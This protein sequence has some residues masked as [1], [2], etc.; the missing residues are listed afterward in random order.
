MKKTIDGLDLEIFEDVY[1]P[2]ED[3]FLLAEN[4]CI[5]SD[6]KILEVGSGSGYVSIYLS[7]KYP[8]AEIFSLDINFSATKCTLQNISRN[9]VELHVINSDL[10]SSFENLIPFFDIILFNSPYLPVS[11]DNTLA[12]AWSGGIDGLTVIR[13]FLFNLSDYL[14]PTGSCYLVVSSYT[15]LIGLISII[16]EINFNYEI[17]D[18]VSEGG[19]KIL[20]YLLKRK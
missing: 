10:F 20:L 3:S 1:D 4:I 15:D 14:K 19:E 16:N 17:I 12:K 2:A 8:S 18:S 7:K 9:S 11:E 6:A 5:N 13:E